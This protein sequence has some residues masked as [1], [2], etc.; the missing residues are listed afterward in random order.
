MPMLNRKQKAM[1]LAGFAFN[2]R[3]RPLSALGRHCA[4]LDR[5]RR[6]F[7]WPNCRSVFMDQ[8]ASNHNSHLYGDPNA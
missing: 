6:R 3:N 2:F 7:I 1:L 4:G 5:R 8:Q